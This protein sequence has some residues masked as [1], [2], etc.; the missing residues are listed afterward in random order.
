ME[1]GGQERGGEREVKTRKAGG[2]AVEDPGPVF[3]L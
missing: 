3:D 2:G 1:G